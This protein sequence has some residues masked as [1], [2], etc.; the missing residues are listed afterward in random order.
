MFPYPSGAGLHVGHPK[1]YTAT[2]VIAR[3]KRLQQYNVLHPM[4]W[5]AFGLPAEQYAY[6]T[7]QDP[8]LFTKQ[9]IAR[10]KQQL[11]SF[12]FMYD[13]EKEINTSDPDYFATTQYIFTLL[14]QK[15]LAYVDQ[16]DVN[17]CAELNT[18][19]ANEEVV[20]ENDQMYSER[21][22]HLVVKKP[23]RQWVLRITKYAEVL[24]AGLDEL[25]WPSS[26]KALQRKWIGKTTVYEVK[27]Q[28]FDNNEHLAVWV[29]KLAD[30]S[31][32][33]AVVI[34]P[35]SKYLARWGL[36]N[37]KEVATMKIL[38][39]FQRTNFKSAHQAVLLAKKAIHPLTKQLIP[40]IVS[41]HILSYQGNNCTFLVPAF[42]KLDAKIAD[43][44]N[45]AW[46]KDV[47]EDNPVLKAFKKNGAYKQKN[48][49]R[50]HDWIF[51]RQRYWGEPFPVLHQPDKTISV[52]NKAELPL[53]LPAF[54][55]RFF[56][57][58]ATS[59]LAHADEWLQV[60]DALRDQNTMPQ[61]A[62]SCWY[63]LAYI[64]KTKDCFMPLNSVAGQ[65]LLKKWMPVDLYIGGQEHAVLHLLYA[66][67]WNLVLYDLKLSPVKEPFQ[68]LI[69]QGMIL[70][71]HQQKMSKSKGNVINP[72]EIIFSHG[73]DALR[74]YELFMGP[75]EQ[76][77]AWNVNGLDACRRWLDRVWRL[78]HTLPLTKQNDHQLSFAFHKMVQQVTTLLEDCKFNNAI[79]ACMVFVNHCYKAKTALYQPY[80]EDF[81]VILAVFAPH[82]S[83]ELYVYLKKAD[84]DI[85][86]CVWPQYKIKYL[87]KKSVQIIVQ[88]NGKF[89]FT[90]SYDQA[91]VDQE[92]MQKTVM[93]EQKVLAFV[94]KKPLKQ[95]IVVLNKVINFVV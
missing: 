24:L 43:L 91:F 74:L 38:A 34:P 70:D 4:G 35:E 68:K 2:D 26:V 28:V 92:T 49:Y 83:Q 77:F 16:I 6:E 29:P 54:N 12:G 8:H 59:A 7:K 52:L 79:S 1:G 50:L 64:L 47:V 46:E 62:G 60:G 11:V 76:S 86:N 78:V 21:G 33:K 55:A 63:Y 81:L 51:S 44:L 27:C 84:I 90:L 18:V 37:E 10:F 80:V 23:M 67:F 82:V 19:L 22:H 75:I 89:K 30:L 45:I 66:R 15:N 5:D 31:A 20:I 41:N 93:Q 71:E 58:Q 3:F 32:V 57:R 17:W 69:N 13:W 72:D 39:D 14:N 61:W 9:N 36:L 95:T 85:T 48:I 56:R 73:A 42:S 53:Q 65:A 94:A 88:V 25:D 87:T 40:I